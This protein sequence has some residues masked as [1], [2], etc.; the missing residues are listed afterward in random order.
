MHIETYIET[1]PIVPYIRESEW[2]ERRSWYLPERRLLDYLL[3][4]VESGTM[5]ATIEGTTKNYQAGDFRFIQ[6]NMHHILEGT[7]NTVTP[8]M[9]FDIFYNSHRKDSFPTKAGQTNL[10]PFEAFL[11]PKLNDFEDINIPVHIQPSNAFRFREL[12]FRIVASWNLQKSASNLEVQLLS[13]ELILMLINDYKKPSFTSSTQARLDWVPAYLQVNLSSPLTLEQ[14][15]KRANLS[16][17][18]F[19]NLFKV[20]F[21]VSPHQYVMELR[22]DHAKYLLKQ[23]NH[24]IE[25]I[26][27]FCGYSD[28]HHFSNAFK[29]QYKASPLQYRKKRPTD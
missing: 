19:R 21:G 8:F 16:P 1:N 26:A 11:Q 22:F 14:M 2:A 6:P 24:T 20:E 25:Q 27:E 18:R 3:V 7:T 15:A 12:F 4:Y 28:I 5:R 13:T 29:K 17:S 9:H 10:S 23:T